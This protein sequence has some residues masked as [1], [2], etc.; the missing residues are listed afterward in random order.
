[1]PSNGSEITIRLRRSHLWAVAGLLIGIGIGVLIGR[2][3]ADD[4]QTVLYGLPATQGE[5]SAATSEG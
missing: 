2:A 4:P 3:T 5:G 1:M